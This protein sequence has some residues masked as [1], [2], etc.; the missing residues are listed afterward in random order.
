MNRLLPPNDAMKAPVAL[1]LCAAAGATGAAPQDALHTFGPQA[2]HIGT[3]W[4]FTLALCT[5]VFVAVLGACIYALWRAPKIA[6]QVDPDMSSLAGPEKGVHRY[7]GWAV[8]FSIAGLLVLLVGDVFTTR[9]IA[10]M[11]LNNA[12]NIELIGHQWWWEARYQFDDPSKN[13]TT[14]NELHI[15]VGRPVLITLNSSDVIHSLWI[16]N[17]HGK[18]DLIPGRTALLR[19][20]ADQP[21]TYRSQCAEFCGLEHA[22]MALLVVAEPN[23]R[24]E[25]WLARQN[26]PSTPP[27]DALAQRGQQVFLSKTCVMCHTIGGTTAQGRFGPNLT[28]LAS[29]ST[30]AAG[31][32]PNNRGYLGGWIA[33]P[34]SL[35]PG[36][37]MPS[38]ALEPD[39]LQ[40]LLA[41]LE[42][43]K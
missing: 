33:D 34:Q 37:N 28:H 2:S 12:V 20:R 24:Y 26:A 32:F 3:L 8:A 23:A 14:A 9:A 5:V 21:G 22:L 39:D 1:M 40:A 30:I 15:P 41:Y 10:R 42:T 6:Q 4:N 17:L 35:K 36:V 11:P 25:A 18:R 19:L 31:M 38:N 16:P 13:F 43:L 7:I 27:S 29:R